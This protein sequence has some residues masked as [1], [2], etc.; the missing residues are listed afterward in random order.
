L[1]IRHRP[2][3]H[4][5][6]VWF[7][8]A[9]E[10]LESRRLLALVSWDG[11]GDR[12]NWFDPLNWSADT[13]PGADDAVEIAAAWGATLPGGALRFAQPSDGPLAAPAR[14]AS[15]RSAVPIAFI[16]GTLESTG[17]QDYT[18]PIHLARGVT[19]HARG[20]DAGNTPGVSI[21]P[22]TTP[23]FDPFGGILH[24]AGRVEAR[25][26][27]IDAGANGV[28]AVYGTL[29]ARTH[30]DGPGGNVTVLGRR[31]VV[32]GGTIDASAPTGGGTVRLGGDRE[33]TGT[34]RR[35]TIAYIGP[36]AVV[37]AD[38][39][40]AG[41]GGSIVVWSDDAT[42]FY[43]IASARGGPNGGDGGF[44]ETSGGS[45]DVTGSADAAAPS[46]DA[47]VWLLDPRNVT[48]AVMGSSTSS[49][50]NPT[51]FTPTT[52]DFAV[53]AS[54][55]QT[56]LNNAI[57]VI[58]TTNGGGTQAGNINLNAA[59][60]R[61]DFG[62]AAP[63]TLTLRAAGDINI[64]ASL[65]SQGR[66]VNM[67]FIAND[68]QPGD[69]TPA[70]GNVNINA[71][72][73]TFNGTFT[74]S[75]VNI[76]IGALL[77][78]GTGTVTLTATNNIALNSAL[79]ITGGT[80]VSLS[81]GGTVSQGTSGELVGAA[82][83]I[84]GSAN[85]MLTDPQNNIQSVRGG[86]TGA[87]A[88]TLTDP[89]GGLVITGTGLSTAGGAVLINSGA[90]SVL[91]PVSVG[92]LGTATFITSLLTLTAGTGTVTANG[93]I[94]VRPQSAAAS[95]QLNNSE[96]SLVQGGFANLVTTGTVSIGD[97]AATGTVSVGA[98]GGTN[99]NY[100]L[101]ITGGTISI[102][103]LTLAAGKTL[104]LTARTG[105][106]NQA[107]G[108]IIAPSLVVN[109]L[110]LSSVV[111]LANNNIQS[112]SGSL[113]G[114]LLVQT[115][116]GITVPAAGIA[117]SGAGQ[118]V[119]LF[120]TG[121]INLAGGISVPGAS[122]V[123]LD[124]SSGSIV[125][126][127][128]A[129]STAALSAFAQL[130]VSLPQANPV[131]LV[132]GRASS[133]G[134]L[135]N[136]S[137]P[138][139]IG[140]VIEDSGIIASGNVTVTSTGAI[141]IADSVIAGAAL[142]LS[143]GT[144]GVGGIT[145]SQ[146]FRSLAG[147]SVSLRA[148]DGPGGGGTTSAIDATTN[149]P[150]ILGPN[151]VPGTSP[152]SFAVRQDASVSGT[153]PAVPPASAFGAGVAGLAYSVRSDE[154]SVTLSAA[155]L[156]R[157]GST[158][159]SVNSATGATFSAPINLA[160]LTTTGALAI[161]GNVAATGAVSV[162][163]LL[164]VSAA[165]IVSGSAVSLTGGI[166]SVLAGFALTVN[167]G[168]ATALGGPAAPT[169]VASL[170][171]DAAGTLTLSGVLR[172]TGAMA[173]GEAPTLSG[174]TTIE[175][176]TLTVG[177]VTAGPHNLTINADD[178]ALNGN[179]TGTGTV[180]IAP[181][182]LSRAV[183]VGSGAA[184]TGLAL[185]NTEL[186]RLVNGFSKVV[187]G[188]NDST[189]PL[190]IA[191]T[192]GFAFSDPV[193]FRARGVGASIAVAQPLRGT[194]NA[195]IAVF[196]SGAT[197]TLNADVSTA[198]QTILFD[199]AVLIGVPLV[200]ISTN[201]G[202]PA[203][204]NISFNSGL[205]SEAGEGN[206]LT[207]NAGTSG[208]TTF[209]GTIGAAPG[210]ALGNLTT[211]AGGTTLINGVVVTTLGTQLFNDAVLV[212]SGGTVLTGGALL[213]Q[214]TLDSSPAGVALTLNTTGGGLT[215]F[216]APVGGTNRF[217]SITTNADGV[218]EVQTTTVRTTGQISLSDTVNIRLPGTLFDA[219][220]FNLAAP[221]TIL[222][223]NLPLTISA[224][225]F[226]NL[227]GSIS[228]VTVL[229]VNAT[230]PICVGPGTIQTTGD[231]VYN[232]PL[233][234]CASV[235]ITSTLG[236]LRFNGTVNT[237]EHALTLT[238]TDVNFV[239]AVS[240]TGTLRLRPAFV[241]Q[242][243]SIA[244]PEGGGEFDLTAAEITLLQDGLEE[245]EVGR[246]D[247]EN[248]VVVGD[249][250]FTDPF[251]LT[252]PAGGTIEIAGVLRG[253]GNSRMTVRGVGSTT[254]I[255]GSIITQGQPIEIF[256]AVRLEAASVLIDSTQ[257][258]LFPGG[259][260]RIQN[261]VNA[262]TGTFNNLT[263]RSGA[264]VVT[265]NG[266]VGNLPS[267]EL[268]SLT[269]NA[270]PGG[271]N[272]NGGSI[273]TRTAQTYNGPVTLG[274]PLT[275]ATT[276]NPATSSITFGGTINGA[277]S[278]TVAP[279]SG[280]VNFNG[281]V[282]STTSLASVT[283]NAGGVRR[284]NSPVSVNVLTIFGGDVEFNAAA[285]INSG[286]LIAGTLGGTGVVTVNQPLTWIGGTMLGTGKTVIAPGGT[287]VIADQQA[288]TLSRRIENQGTT[289]WTGGGLSFVG[290]QFVNMPTGVF[291]AQSPGGAFTGASGA[292][293]FDN[294]GLLERSGNAGTSAFTNLTL[295]NTGTLRAAAGTLSF[296]PAGVGVGAFTNAGT[297][298][299]ATGATV[300]VTGNLALGPSST[301]SVELAGT[302][303]G[304]FG[305]LTATGTVTLD[306]NLTATLAPAF[307][308]ALFNAFA[309]V[310][311]PSVG[312]FFASSN[313]PAAPMGLRFGISLPGDAAVIRL[314]V[315]ADFNADGVVNPDDLSDFITAFFS[316]PPGAGADFNGDGVVNPDDLSD[317]ITAFFGV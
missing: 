204:A 287:L 25:A 200:T 135:L 73:S 137:V 274:G 128:G 77:S 113:A 234:T 203:G 30:H 158:A 164:T 106:I 219:G 6:P 5:S 108:V 295:F 172:A 47:G 165:S 35:A 292:N 29:D 245:I 244:G 315:A 60:Q 41:D 19:L 117:V 101:S 3:S 251:A 46:G 12:L 221:G 145:V 297:I 206:S 40:D 289:F 110:A 304:Q 74:A 196:G 153:A 246:E 162:T 95:F 136:A 299:I 290:G 90:V 52:D 86:L 179:L 33:G 250:T 157:V 92:G 317:F 87:G 57:S 61:Q 300:A 42:G 263:I 227:F 232:G 277:Q 89:L 66:V 116:T 8:D 222:G 69:P 112:V 114:S 254:A 161:A 2:T 267:G 201:I 79:S 195:S 163:G 68:A 155:A 38:A 83:V 276:G 308:P 65:S 21:K 261:A 214:S 91:A 175:A 224:T 243:V 1:T 240:G 124:T 187:I 119:T 75:G 202:V 142:S 81:A 252:N 115:T 160:S 37:R 305:V 111:L 169:P 4:R 279:G 166:G 294:R 272:L 239:A 207:L 286:L 209:N 236:V 102:N 231:Q 131:A 104:T 314:T 306:G 247:G 78:T 143:A 288:K 281:G 62:S 24:L 107:G 264:G 189:G 141:I 53:Q 270:Q 220:S 313:L 309:V 50:G 43:G 138:L 121:D 85:Y 255:S 132:T 17:G 32:D 168:G 212:L 258:G 271:I 105:S 139:T 171:T 283:V 223:N 170:A 93:G 269:I 225:G 194:G 291:F 174:A 233:T 80:T 310:T 241:T 129:V 55:I 253:T 280:T 191:T 63:A 242:R 120:A 262:L 49:L 14:V 235:S 182:T 298:S 188:R 34:L 71:S 152:T 144:V 97:P 150:S 193:E 98:L 312:G 216:L 140:T 7:P 192:G 303:P 76:T 9:L 146:T 210:G 84:A 199:D 186:G 208:N 184:G 151:A 178:A 167:S 70:A 316:A 228:G 64:N 197:T 99:L 51:T 96:F 122:R 72:I 118:E 10:A 48:I 256:D 94:F 302:A 156:A 18:A 185:S 183:F 23:A 149:S 82:L 268:G 205:S 103:S 226:V 123:R 211:D 248:E 100:N 173:F 190:T 15:V 67:V 229:I 147:L 259:L 159:L 88:L 109:T 11:G 198:G 13:L 27:F 293:T 217:L 31:V 285:T 148:G 44:I 237:Q 307:T 301:L 230:Q 177:A 282:G 265:L 266:P 45:L 296:A 36:T 249:A 26:I 22:S 257:G 180:T 58:V 133:G 273:R 16:A 125:Q 28:A 260:V 311:A 176:Q 218:L 134:F 59:I 56:A 39:T 181:R 215:R 154:G 284:F 238:G 278:L 275:V 213:F 130:G 54:A 127:G 20:S 126:S